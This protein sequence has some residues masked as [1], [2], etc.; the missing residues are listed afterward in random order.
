MC[1]PGLMDGGFNQHAIV[2]VP[3]RS[4]EFQDCYELDIVV[5]NGDV[6]DEECRPND[7]SEDEGG[8]GMGHGDL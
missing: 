5:P 6:A 8:I 2:P 1:L 3:R 4:P 7:Y